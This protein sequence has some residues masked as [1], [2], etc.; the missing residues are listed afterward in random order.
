MLKADKIGIALFGWV[1]ALIGLVTIISLI[2]AMFL[3]GATKPLGVFLF[4]FLSSLVS[5][6]LGIGILRYQ[7]WARK[8]LMFF[9]GYI[10]L[11]KMLIFLHLILLS[12]P[13]EVLIPS[14]AKNSVSL[15]YHIGVILFF[16]SEKIRLY[17]K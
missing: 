1:E 16:N 17:F 3:W 8:V 4:V 12:P 6:V 11:T 14:P 15:V 5:L 9:A 7:L 13:F 2:E 10:I